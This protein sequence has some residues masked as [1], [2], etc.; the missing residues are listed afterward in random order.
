MSV[1]K[2]KSKETQ[3]WKR[4][5]QSNYKRMK[6]TEPAKFCTVSYFQSASFATHEEWFQQVQKLTIVIRS[7]HF[8]SQAQNMND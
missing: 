6:E 4:K 2:L 8:L 7:E 1:I 5:Q 3:G